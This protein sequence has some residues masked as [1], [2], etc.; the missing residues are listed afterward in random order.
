MQNYKGTSYAEMVLQ[1]KEKFGLEYTTTQMKAFY[2]N[3][4]LDSGL[5]GRFEPG[6]VP[7]NK[8]MKGVYGTGCEKGWFK[9]GGTPPTTKPLGYE[10]VNTDGYTLVK[11]RMEPSA[12]GKHDRFVPKH[13]YLYE[14]AYGPIPPD[15]AIM[16]KDGNRQNLELSNLV[17]VSRAELRTLNKRHLI[18]SDP[19]L[20]ETGIALVKLRQALAE[21]KRKERKNDRP[22]EM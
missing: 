17:M 1:I 13:R 2:G 14:K 4:H 20:T 7:F 10:Y 19:E 5:T 11:V 3:R 18:S 15:C 9:K 6:H 8:G 12:P 16:F 22:C 21:V